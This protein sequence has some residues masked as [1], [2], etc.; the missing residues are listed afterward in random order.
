MATFSLIVLMAALSGL[1]LLLCMVERERRRAEGRAAGM[2]QE[3]AQRDRHL[4]L[5]ARE[6]QGLGLALLGQ[7]ARQP[8][9][10]A[11]EGHARTLLCLAADVH[12]LAAAAAA[13]RR[14][15]EEAVPL[16]PLLREV[17]EQVSLALAPGTRHWRIAPDLAALVLFADRRALK[18][19]LV[20]LL[21]RA[22][23]HTREGDPIDLR[24][25]QAEETLSILVEDEG[26]GLAASDL[27]RGAAG[28]GTRGLGL[29]LVLARQLL[30]AHEGELT[31]EAVPGL[32]AR[33]W[34]TLPRRRLLRASPAPA[35]PAEAR[36]RAGQTTAPLVRTGGG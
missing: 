4:G 30:R 32:G 27:G 13:P 34:M 5:F 23:R 33:S 9:G 12:D 31:V 14:L 26:A 20:E 18:G 15:R 22:A 7:A 28:D 1:G 24:L 8:P 16:A 17:V 25:V 29:G 6:L 19:A 10:G 3:L 21:A 11:L 36:G 35:M 2:E